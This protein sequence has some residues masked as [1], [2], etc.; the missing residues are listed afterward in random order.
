MK[1]A[2]GTRS[3]PGTL[4][5]LE[6]PPPEPPAAPWR[7]ILA[8]AWPVLCQQYLVFLVSTSDRFLA[9]W[10]EPDVAFQAAQTT[11]NYL[12]WVIT[13]YTVLVYAGSAALVARLIG[14]G[15]RPAA[16]HATNQALL[17]A[18]GLGLAGTLVGVAGSDHIALLLGL[19]GPT[20][21]YAAA[22]LRLLFL[23][24][25]FQMIEMT[26]IYCLVGAGDTRPGLYVLGGVALVNI[27]LGWAFFYLLG[28]PGIAL[29]TTVS[30]LL[31]CLVVL[32]MLARGRAG[33]WLRPDLLWP[34]RELLWRLLRVGVPAGVD[35]MSV[36]LSQLWFLRI[37][38]G[39]GDVASGAHGIA[40]GW[41]SLA[42]LS[43]AAFGT[44][45][46]A[47]VGQN[48]GA[49]RPDRAARFGWTAFALGCGVMSA[50]GL[51]FFVLARPMFLLYCP[52]PEK[53]EVITQGVQVL[54]LVAF[55]M[56]ALAST[57]IF[58]AALRGA[59]DT[60]VPL[61]FTWTG[62]LLVRIPLA[63]LFTGPWFGWGLFGA[64]LAMFADL[65]VRGGFFLAR[66][67]GGR[68]QRAVV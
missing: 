46:M 51:L 41:E 24:A 64:W 56:P 23:G 14:A 65:M 67:A 59:G 17:L 40:L 49:L 5:K 13:S 3:L 47:L 60:R 55:A 62:F 34:D 18:A 26:G 7:A 25:V 30:N 42:Y 9:G 58:T 19:Q 33:L 53:H 10:F 32:L 11:A 45:T 66:F 16:V 36:A 57:Q 52:Q 61:L 43:G 2:P 21:A 35:S 12:S 22:Y 37:V 38:N 50:M 4:G 63:Y 44:A 15:D 54:R 1:P 6:S 28:F 20:A 31:G 27:P 8:L 29:G 68:W 48:L 39:L